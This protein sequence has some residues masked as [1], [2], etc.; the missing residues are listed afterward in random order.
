[1]PK[2]EINY[3]KTVIYKLVC[4][5]VTVTDCYV[6]STTSF[7]KR[8]YSHKSRCTNVKNSKH[9]LNVYQFIRNNG[10][11]IN[12]DMVQIERF[13][14]NDS[15]EALKREGY[16]I[17]TLKATLNKVIPTR[18]KKE[19]MDNYNICNAIQ[20]KDYRIKNRDTMNEKKKIHYEKNKDTI[21][22]K[23]KAY[24]IK[25]KEV[26]QK[27]EKV[28]YNQ[29]KEI[30]KQKQ[31]IRIHCNICNCEFRKAGKA[32]HERSTKHKNFLTIV[33][34]KY[35]DIITKSTSIQ[36]FCIKFKNA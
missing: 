3:S 11:W 16:W 28:Y 8:K 20:R 19:Y 10:G 25:N 6:G 9:H 21:L 34:K 5:D 27:R 32:E 13:P 29:N 17:E 4:K 15:N 22:S 7:T 24:C 30:I 33:Q 26:I 2:K 1:M 35:L 14:F 12:W 31:K 36:D 18:T 23:Q